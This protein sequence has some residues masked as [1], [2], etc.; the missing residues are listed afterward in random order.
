M[1][2]TSGTP[3]RQKALRSIYQC[4]STGPVLVPGG[5]ANTVHQPPNLFVGFITTLRYQVF[6]TIQL[7][8]G[9]T[10]QEANTQCSPP[11]HRWLRLEDFPFTALCIPS[12]P[13]SGE[14]RCARGDPFK[15][16]GFIRERA[17]IRRTGNVCTWKRMRGA[18][19]DI[20]LW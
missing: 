20:A 7:K 13:A 10:D 9:Q 3:Q 6:S 2:R 11:S 12:F 19:L 4:W 17:R 15:P 16:S 5:P 8:A 1:T 14:R 18:I